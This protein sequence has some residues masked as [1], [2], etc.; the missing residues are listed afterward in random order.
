MRIECPQCGATGGLSGQRDGEGIR[1]TCGSCGNVWVRYPD[2]CPECGEKALASVRA[3]L[4]QKAR[5][6]QQSIIA[7]RI[8]KEC[9]V[10]GARIGSESEPNAT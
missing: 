4:Y 5:G 2:A 1:I 10:C 9:Q 7:Y 8:V 3:P 6:T